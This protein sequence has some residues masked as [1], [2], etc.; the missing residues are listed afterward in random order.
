MKSET[1][2]AGLILQRF[3]DLKIGNFSA[4]YASYHAQSP[5]LQQ[6]LQ[7]EDYVEFAAQSL[8]GLSPLEVQ[9]GPSRD[10][11]EGVEVICMMVFELN[12]SQQTLYEL[13]LLLPTEDGWRYHSA[14][15]LT[16]EDFG[17]AFSGLDFSH[18]DQQAIK[19]RF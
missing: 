3:E 10:S 11:G 13:A 2:P 7:L 17:G 4:L 14:Q 8:A 12:G 5:F 15:K 1:T 9:T 19:V 16:P 18:F 6:F